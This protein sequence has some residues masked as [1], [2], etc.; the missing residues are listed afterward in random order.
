M[1]AALYWLRIQTSTGIIKAYPPKLAPIASVFPCSIN[2]IVCK[3]TTFGTFW[4]ALKVWMNSGMIRSSYYH[5][6][7][8]KPIGHLEG[9][10]PLQILDEVHNHHIAHCFDYLRQALM[11]SADTTIEWAVVQSTGERRQVD[12]WGIPHKTCK[13]WDVL[14]HW[15]SKHKAPA[16]YSGIL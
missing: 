9:D 14:L 4:A 1:A 16:D 2:S 6:N 8:T 3:Y 5:R 7:G 12:G 15:M 11:C 13:N 10:L